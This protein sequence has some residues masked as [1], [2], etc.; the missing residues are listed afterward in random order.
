MRIALTGSH[1]VGKTTLFDNLVLPRHNK[2]QEAARAEIARQGKLPHEMSE[3]EF[4]NF[5]LSLVHK[6][7]ELE[8]GDFIAD[9]S[10]FDMLAYAQDHPEHHLLRAI[11]EEHYRPYDYV[12]YIP[13]EFALV[14]DDVRKDDLRYQKTIDERIKKLLAEYQ[15]NY[16]TISGAK[17]RRLDLIHSILHKNHDQKS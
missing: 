8:Q 4:F 6:Q 9:R 10:L 1:G 13:I 2:I 14:I 12:F 17:E 5:Q 7:I 11:I 16:I 3:E 15:I